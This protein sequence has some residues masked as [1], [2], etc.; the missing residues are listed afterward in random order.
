MV[1]EERIYYIEVVVV[2]KPKNSVFLKSPKND[3]GEKG[4]GFSFFGYV[5]NR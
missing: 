2:K 3:L 1:G 4:H 5:K